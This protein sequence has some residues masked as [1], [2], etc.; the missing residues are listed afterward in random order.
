MFELTISMRNCFALVFLFLLLC[1]NAL[2]SNGQFNF[3]HDNG[4][5][6]KVGYISRI[7]RVIRG[8]KE[9]QTESLTRFR[10]HEA[11]RAR[12][13]PFVHLRVLNSRR[14]SVRLLQPYLSVFPGSPKVPK[15]IGI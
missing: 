14:G 9:R 4:V 11:Q 12:W 1:Y 8:C 10:K 6:V 13:N 3:F 2:R 7:R 15:G 5:C